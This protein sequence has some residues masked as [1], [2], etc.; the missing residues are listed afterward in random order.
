MFAGYT[1]STIATDTSI[2]DVLTSILDAASYD[3]AP[4]RRCAAV[5]LV[6]PWCHA[7]VA[8]VLGCHSVGAC[9][10]A[11]SHCRNALARR[12]G[13]PQA[14]CRPASRLRLGLCFSVLWRANA[15]P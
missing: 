3:D 8:L 1:D 6:L 13:H 9:R 11:L 5:A 14:G 4:L 15:M 10:S 12:R 7:A 2:I